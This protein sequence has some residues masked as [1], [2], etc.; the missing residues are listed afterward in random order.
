MT[1]AF[2]DGIEFS[3]KGIAIST[4]KSTESLLLN[5]IHNSLADLSLK[6]ILIHGAIG[7]TKLWMTLNPECSYVDTRFLTRIRV[8]NRQILNHARAYW[9]CDDNEVESI[10]ISKLDFAIDL[11]G[12]FLARPSNE[13]FSV[14]KD[15]L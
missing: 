9:S 13:A 8:L 10:E 4:V 2:C 7:H 12:S 11:E 14:F 6:N 1:T 5:D 15:E 3:L